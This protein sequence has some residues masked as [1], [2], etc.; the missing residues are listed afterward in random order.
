MG[1][2]V[3]CPTTIWA[4]S[5]MDCTDFIKGRKKKEKKKRNKQHQWYKKILTRS[6][7]SKKKRFE[8]VKKNLIYY[9]KTIWVIII[10][11]LFVKFF[12]CSTFYLYRRTSSPSPFNFVIPLFNIF[13]VL[14][15]FIFYFLHHR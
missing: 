8:K 1:H 7:R 14:F 12:F 3:I 2:P 9:I 4:S 6:M 10:T 13:P 15:F 11:V 5:L